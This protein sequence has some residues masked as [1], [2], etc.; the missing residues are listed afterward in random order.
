MALTS[1][2]TTLG[3]KAGSSDRKPGRLLNLG[4]GAEPNAS[5][6]N[7]DIRP[8]PN[9]IGHDLR[10]GI[11]FPDRTFDLVYHS[12]MLSQLRPAEALAL[13]LECYRVLKPGG[14]LRAVTEDLE[15]MCR[16]YLQKLEDAVKGDSESANDYDWM[17]LEIYDQATRESPGG[18][19]ADYLRQNPLPNEKFVISRIGAQG[20][21][22]IAGVRQAQ[23]GVQT[24]PRTGGAGSVFSRLKGLMRK[25]LLT[26]AFGPEA[27]AA[28]E[29][30]RFRLS[31]GQ[32]TY[33][34]YDRFSLRQLFAKAGFTDIYVRTPRQSAYPGWNEV[35]LDLNTDGTVARPHTI[36]MEGARSF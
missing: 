19:M 32:V 34:M 14:V 2:A 3:P 5:F 15:Q 1:D 26:M 29:I 28:L 16:L 7:V 27:P 21:R 11:P 30:G 36:I 12:T 9:I 18:A 33:R 25:R 8:G 22:I 4:C 13:T 31:G 10:R 20:E 35:N 24:A 6:V 23:L 17:I